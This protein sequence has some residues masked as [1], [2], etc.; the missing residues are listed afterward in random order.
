ME[1]LKAIRMSQ[2]IL[3]AE[4]TERAAIRQPTYAN[5]E[6]GWRLPSVRTA[7]RIAAVLGFDWHKFF[8]S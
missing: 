2:K 6:N 1:W 3:Q 8:E 5:I 4:V 7:Q